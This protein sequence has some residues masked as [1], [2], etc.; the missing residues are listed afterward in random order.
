LRKGLFFAGLLV[1]G[2]GFYVVLLAMGII[3]GTDGNFPHWIVGLAGMAFVVGGGL[4]SIGEL[5]KHEDAIALRDIE[6]AR[7]FRNVMVVFLLLIF[8]ILGNWV[9]FGPGTRPVQ[10]FLGLP[11]A[12]ISS[13]TGEWLGRFGFGLGALTVDILLFVSLLSIV[14]GRRKRPADGD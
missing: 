1:L 3:P 13:H 6:V 11:F 7:A 4:V 2:I 12:D 14:R 8:A 5:M 10:A 9:A